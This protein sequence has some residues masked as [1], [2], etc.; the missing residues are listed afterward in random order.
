[1][2]KLIQKQIDYLNRPTSI[3]QIESIIN[4][5]PKRKHKAQMNSLM[6]PTKHGT[7]KLY[8]FSTSSI[9]EK[10]QRKYFLTYSRKPVTPEKC[11]TRNL[12]TNISHSIDAEIINKILQ[13]KF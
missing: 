3:N 4:N 11:I 5:L 12:P 9:R 10:K 8:Q 1:M 13:I 7:K 6:N 2:P